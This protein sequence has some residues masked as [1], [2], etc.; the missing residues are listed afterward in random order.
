M[1]ELGP[2]IVSVTS[3][4]PP[5]LP[6]PKTPIQGPDSPTHFRQLDDRLA[7]VDR[8]DDV[9]EATKAVYLIAENET[10][11]QYIPNCETVATQSSPKK[12]EVKQDPT[13]NPE[14]PPSVYSEPFPCP[15]SF[16]F[17]LSAQINTQP[18]TK[19]PSFH[20]APTPTN[21]TLPPHSQT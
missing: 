17:P 3:V 6:L 16:E 19:E 14:V 9:D 1:I 20:S 11:T 13:A 18:G 4:G 2:D 21:I 12:D 7:G 15:P 8:R 10:P 5:L